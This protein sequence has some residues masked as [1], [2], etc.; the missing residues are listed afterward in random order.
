MKKNQPENKPTQWEI[1]Q[2][3]D[4]F[5]ENPVKIKIPLGLLQ[6]GVLDKAGKETDQFVASRSRDF[7]TSLI[8][9]TADIGHLAE[10]LVIW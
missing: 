9:S 7:K 4:V 5:S 3:S 2:P 10:N 6:R 1:G 8:H